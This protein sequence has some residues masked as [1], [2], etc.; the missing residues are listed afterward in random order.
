MKFYFTILFISVTL[1]SCKKNNEEPALNIAYLG[2]EIINPNTNYIVLSKDET[3]LDTVYLDG[4]NRF[5]YKIDNLNKGIYT[6]RHGGEYQLVLL[7]PEDSLLFRLNTL[8]F[9]ESL[10]YSG[11]GDDK[12]N[13]FI[14]EYIENEKEEKYII[15]ICQLNGEDFQKKADSLK[16]F[17][18]ERLNRFVEKNDPSDLFL[19]IAHANIDYKYYLSKE[20]YPFVH[21]GENKAALLKSLP[22]NFYNYRKEINYNDS[23]LTNH[24]GYNKFLRYNLSNLSLK[25]H[26][27][28]EKNACFDKKSLCFNLDR[29]KLIDSLIINPEVKDDLLYHFTIGYLAKSK[30]IEYN[31]ELLKTY[32]SI[33][34]SE[35]GKERMLRFTSSVNNLKNG[36][37]LPNIKI[38]GY[39]DSEYRLNAKVYAPT[40]LCFW[41]FKYFDHFKESHYKIKEL[42][43]KYP[44]INFISINMDGKNIE[45]S[46]NLLKGNGFYS[47]NEYLFKNPEVASNVLAIYPMTKTILVD[48]NNKIV[49]SNTNMFSVNFEEQLLGLINR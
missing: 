31:K 45:K 35:K 4:K 5:L 16:D 7:E 27:D 14:N 44:E 9:D 43:V 46:K 13:Y 42:K 2:G 3:I 11:K 38:F 6:F 23:F 47:P 24:H 29:L 22:K 30:N 32:L 49:N 12:N 33:S 21:V 18:A 25:T 39:D 28:H 1:F 17:K 26:D 34:K 19:K 40:V 10:V 8:D 37:K 20:V 41:S 36:D 15:K 48:K